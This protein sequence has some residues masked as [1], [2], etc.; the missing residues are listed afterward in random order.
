MNQIRPVNKN[1]FDKMQI[2][3]DA[4]DELFDFSSVRV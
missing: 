1:H 2:A 3:A 4:F